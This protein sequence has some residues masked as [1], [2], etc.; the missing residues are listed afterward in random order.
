MR[1]NLPFV[2][3]KHTLVTYNIT[4]SLITKTNQGPRCFQQTG[5]QVC[6]GR[7][8]RPPR[9]VQLVLVNLTRLC[10]SLPVRLADRLPG[11]PGA[12]QPPQ[13]SSTSF[14]QIDHIIQQSGSQTGRKADSQTR[15]GSTAPRAVLP[16]VPRKISPTASFEAPPTSLPNI[17]AQFELHF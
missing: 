14:G 13:G 4:L 2:S 5:R 16:V 1:P 3:A 6:Q 11:L 12:V 15:G 17:R 9:T 10:S 8:N 7:F